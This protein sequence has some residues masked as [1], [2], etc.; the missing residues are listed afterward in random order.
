MTH[1]FKSVKVR[2]PVPATGPAEV[3]RLLAIA[4]QDGRLDV[5]AGK[6]KM[7]RLKCGHYL[8]VSCDPSGN[9]PIQVPMHD[10]SAGGL[11]FWIRKRL[12]V[13]EAVY[14]RDGSDSSAYPWLRIQITHCDAG[15]KGFLTGGKFD[16]ATGDSSKSK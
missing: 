9:A 14:I 4:T 12:S 16:F 3:K 5:Y 11:S 6:R 1:P 10:I 7:S 15:I 13:G 8:D 2:P